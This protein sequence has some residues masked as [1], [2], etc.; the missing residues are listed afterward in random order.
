MSVDE[1]VMK[2]AVELL[3][4]KANSMLA[5]MKGFV[6]KDYETYLNKFPYL[7]GFRQFS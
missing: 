5:K 7:N 3:T 6:I 4:K 2:N 1:E